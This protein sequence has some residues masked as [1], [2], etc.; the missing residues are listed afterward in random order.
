MTGPRRPRCPPPRSTSAPRRDGAR[1]GSVA[2]IRPERGRRQQRGPGRLDD[3]ERDQHRQ[4][5]G[6]PAGGRGGD[7]HR[8]PEQEGVLPPVALGQPPEQ[9]QEGGVDDRVAV[10]HPREVAEVP[11]PE[12]EVVPDLG[13]RDVDDEQV[14]AG[15]HHAG[16]HDRQH[17]RGRRRRGP[18][19]VRGWLSDAIARTLAHW[20]R[21]RVSQ[22]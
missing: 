9:H 18:Q 8:H 13:Q 19:R 1:A 5:R 3:P 15:E 20:L 21:N 14:E 16:A 6:Q 4:A 17:Q 12:V 7:E 11:G 2:R 22:L 10:Q